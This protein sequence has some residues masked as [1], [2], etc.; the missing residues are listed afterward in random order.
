MDRHCELPPVVSIT[1]YSG[2]GD[3]WE[4]VNHVCDRHGIPAADETLPADTGN[5]PER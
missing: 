5:R 2:G 4:R 3:F 1:E